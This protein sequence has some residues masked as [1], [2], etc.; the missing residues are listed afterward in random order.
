MRIAAMIYHLILLLL[1]FYV[2]HALQPSAYSKEDFPDPRKE[3]TKCGQ[4][5]RSYICDPSQ[6][7]TM[8]VGMYTA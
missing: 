5:K 8:L 2:A 7:L 4:Q 6:S 3:F 1:C